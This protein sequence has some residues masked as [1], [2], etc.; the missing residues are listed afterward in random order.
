MTSST[1]PRA[2]LLALLKAG[3]MKQYRKV[4]AYVFVVR[5]DLAAKLRK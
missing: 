3:L 5:P 4:S 2:D 1:R